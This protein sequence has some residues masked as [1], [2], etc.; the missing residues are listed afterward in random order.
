MRWKLGSLVFATLLV[1]L[2]ISTPARG[3]ACRDGCTQQFQACRNSCTAGPACW[4]ICYDIYQDCL[5]NS[6]GFCS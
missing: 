1:V 3:D 5:C 4:S 2:A 6:C